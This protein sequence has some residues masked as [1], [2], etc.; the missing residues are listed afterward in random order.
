MIFS[1][2][3]FF[4]LSYLTLTV[5]IAACALSDLLTRR[6]P[7]PLIA[8]GLLCTVASRLGMFLHSSGALQG[9]LQYMSVSGVLR[10]LADM[11]AGFLLPY[12]LLG[13]L[14]RLKMLGGG[15]VKLLSVIGLHV[16]WRGCMRM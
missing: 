9:V 1:V 4:T 13:V 8:C 3:S 15:D 10:G 5:F 6:I 2:L 11:A 12:F 7:N 16:G 14:V